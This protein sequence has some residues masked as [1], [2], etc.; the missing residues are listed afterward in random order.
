[1]QLID[2]SD[3]LRRLREAWQR[4]K[5]GE[6]AVGHVNGEAGIGKSR[7]IRALRAEVRSEGAAESVL[8]CSPHH[9]STALYPAAR[10]LEQRLG[11][12]KG[13]H[14]R[15]RLAELAKGVP[16]GSGDAVALLADLLSIPIEP[17]AG[18]LLTPRDA[19][20][21]TLQILESLLVAGS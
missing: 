7:L 9:A 11:A 3:E 16:A 14:S 19:R 6:S 18:G 2:R 10:F 13:E 4:A 5:R 15:E 1:I 21:A 8:Q 17:V 12:I 20:N